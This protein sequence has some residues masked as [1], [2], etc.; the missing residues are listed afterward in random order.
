MAVKKTHTRLS[1]NV[2][3]HKHRAIKEQASLR[4]LS[5]ADYIIFCVE[6]AFEKE[7]VTVEE[8]VVVSKAAKAKK[9]VAAKTSAKAKK[10]A[11]SAS[12]K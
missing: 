9:K 3:S 2:P 8:I 6:E 11:K 7:G 1:L 12:K 4:G 10:P 5:V